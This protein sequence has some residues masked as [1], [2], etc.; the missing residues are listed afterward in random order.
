MVKREREM[1]LHKNDLHSYIRESNAMDNIV[2]ETPE[3]HVHNSGYPGATHDVVYAN[4]KSES[5]VT[6]KYTLHALLAM[7]AV[8]ALLA[9]IGLLCLL[10]SAQSNNNHSDSS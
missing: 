8:L 10:C 9:L 2:G 4:V 6:N 1:N 3:D 7:L 5:L